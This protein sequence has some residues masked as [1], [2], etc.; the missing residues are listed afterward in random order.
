MSI[1]DGDKTH[2]FA[3]RLPA[4]LDLGADPRLASR[5]VTRGL[6]L[7]LRNKLHRFAVLYVQ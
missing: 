3:F 1:F 4:L 5:L 6:G 2:D 7:S